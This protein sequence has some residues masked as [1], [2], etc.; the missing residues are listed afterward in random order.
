MKT[1]IVALLCVG[2][3][4]GVA[5]A[6]LEKGTYAPDIEARDWLNTD[7]PVSLAELRGMTVM[8]FFWVSWHPGGEYVIPMMNLFNSRVGRD[9]GVYLLGVTDSDR[10]RVGEMI[11]KQ[12]VFFPVAL[13]SNSYE[14]YRISGFPRVVIIDPNGKVAWTGWPDS[15]DALYTVAID[16]L[17]EAP[18]TKTHPEDAKKVRRLL[19]EARGALGQD[20][21]R[22]AFKAAREAH[23][24]ALTGD[25]LKTECQDVLDLVEALGRDQLARAEQAVYEKDFE[26]AVSL[27]TNVKRQFRVLDAGALA[28]KK[29]DELKGRY[30]EVARIIQSENEAQTA[31]NLLAEALASLR[32][33]GRGLVEIGSAYQKLGQIV[34]EYADTPTAEKAQTVLGRMQQ[35]VGVMNHVTDFKAKTQCELLLSQARSFEQTN[36]P[37]RAA[38]LYRKV[39]DEYAHTIWADLAAQRLRK[40]RL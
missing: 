37:E 19:G 15:V 18:P 20:N 22:D 27:L 39:I 34:E 25:E 21:L 13:E 16:L 14:D 1:A 11:A 8:M 40:L 29:L 3:A 4:A 12:K 9:Q 10:A 33:P 36:R 6:D 17:A 2:F 7:E 5:R 26:L 35:N 28:R 23:E 32:T 24:L 30:D 38:E 31:E